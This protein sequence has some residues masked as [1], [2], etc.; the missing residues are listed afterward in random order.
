MAVAFSQF[1]PS[2]AYESVRDTFQLFTAAL[3]EPN[4]Q[5]DAQKLAEYYP[6]R[7]ALGLRL[8]SAQGTPIETGWIHSADWRD[9]FPDAELEIEAQVADPTFWAER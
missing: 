3:G 2:V 9:E 1:S 6:A 5:V 7:D 4:S 8:E